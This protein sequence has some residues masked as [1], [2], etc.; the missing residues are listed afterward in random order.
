MSPKITLIRAAINEAPKLKRREAVTRGAVTTSQK[1]PQPNP[2]L[3]MNTADSGISTSSDRYTM[4]YP[5]VRP[6]P[7]STRC[8]FGLLISTAATG[9]AMRV[10]NQELGAIAGAI[11]GH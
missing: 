5:R 3:R 2:R 1:W 10:L 6:K 7:G 4:V 8:G 11:A 9:L